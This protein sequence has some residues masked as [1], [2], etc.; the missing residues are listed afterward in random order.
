MSGA[1]S[2]GPGK[3]RHPSC[4]SCCLQALGDERLHISVTAYPSGHLLGG[5]MWRVT[6]SGEELLFVAGVNHRWGTVG[7]GLQ[8]LPQRAQ[9]GP[10]CALARAQLLWCQYRKMDPSASAVLWLLSP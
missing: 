6:V 1:G 7:Q 8:L 10:D 9:G 2:T 5:A 4:V 3:E